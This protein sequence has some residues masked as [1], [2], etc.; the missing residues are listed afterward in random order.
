MARKPKSG[1]TIRGIILVKF[2]GETYKGNFTLRDRWL[3][4]SCRYGPNKGTSYYP[5]PNMTINPPHEL[6]EQLLREIIQEAS[7]N[8]QLDP[9]GDADEISANAPKMNPLS[10]QSGHCYYAIRCW[11]CRE[12]LPLIEAPSGAS[13][14]EN[15][16]AQ[17]RVRGFMV[18]CMCANE[19]L[20][21]GMIFV[22]GRRNPRAN[23]YFQHP[24]RRTTR[25]LTDLRRARSI[26]ARIIVRKVLTK[27]A[28]SPPTW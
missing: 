2:Q 10:A 9:H 17:E 5:S 28:N 1:E 23:E 4:V 16:A 22:G 24:R 25:P 27:A 7:Q 6:A 26:L 3:E 14:E 20:A 12:Y 18:R 15:Q 19:T 13:F 21:E 8:G 11:N